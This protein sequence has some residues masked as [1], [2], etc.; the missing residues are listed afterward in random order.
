MSTFKVQ[1]TVHQLDYIRY[2]SATVN[3][4]IIYFYYIIYMISTG[5]KILKNYTKNGVINIDV[6]GTKELEELINIHII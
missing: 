4:M 1:M 5:E 2:G 6:S 3:H